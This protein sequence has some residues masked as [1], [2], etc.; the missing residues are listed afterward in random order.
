MTTPDYYFS[1]HEPF[2]TRPEQYADQSEVTIQAEPGLPEPSRKERTRVL[3]EWM[4]FLSH[5]TPI[6]RLSLYCEVKNELLATLVNQPQLEGLQVHATKFTNFEVLHSLTNLR[7]LHLGHASAVTSLDGLVGLPLEVLDLE[8][9]WKITDYSRLGDLTGLVDLRVGPGPGGNRYD[10]E[11]I[12]FLDSLFRLDTLYWDPRVRSLDFTPILRLTQASMIGIR[13]T[14]GMNPSYTN[15]EWCV[16]GVRAYEERNGRKV[17]PVFVDGERRGTI[18]QDITGRTVINS[19][20]PQDSS[21][22]DT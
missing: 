13:K 21:A 8:N 6:R 11:S 17:I 7:I 20:K 18:E 3:H 15:L 9:T 10:S 4:E 22:A 2:L 12:G 14:K 5:P 16:P 19:V 1:H